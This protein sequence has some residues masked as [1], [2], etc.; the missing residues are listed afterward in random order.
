[1]LPMFLAARI[2]QGMSGAMMVPVGRLA[3]LRAT[4]KKDLVKAIS[5]ITW[6]A[7][8]APVLGPP[9]G[10]WIATHLSWPWIFYVNLP[11]GAV[12]LVAALGLI[13]NHVAEQVRRFDWLGFLLISTSCA[14]LLYG[15]ELIGQNLQQLGVGAAL[16]LVAVVTGG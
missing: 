5:Y 13:P 2:L 4:E 6:P 14:T 9:L 15:L 7:L 1:N 8:I 10:G 12:A 11:L 3:V 16:C